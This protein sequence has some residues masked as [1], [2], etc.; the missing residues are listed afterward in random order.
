MEIIERIKFH[1][2]KNPFYKKYLQTRVNDMRYFVRSC[3]YYLKWYSWKKDKEATGN[4]LYFIID[5]EIK[6]PGLSDRYKA[7]IGCYYI[8]K[9]SGFDFKIVF[10][11]PFK[12]SDY[13]NENE[14]SWT[15]GF[16]ELSYSLQNTRIIPYNGGGKVPRLNKKVKQYHV[17]SY[18]GYDILET[19]KIPNYKIEWGK[20][21][22]SLFTPK[23]FIRKEIQATGFEK[24]AYIAIHL[25]F[26]NALEHF[27][28]EQFNTLSEANKEALIVRCL[29]QIKAIIG[30]NRGVSVI[31]FS[32]SQVFLKRVKE[33]PVHVLDGKIGH[34]SFENEREVIIKTFL[35]FYMISSARQIYVI[36]APEMYG[37]VFSYYA[38]LTGQKEVITCEV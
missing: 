31:V 20:L 15:A 9:Q 5:P 30:K 37:T 22:N 33:L 6:H 36:R 18:I 7:I 35:D 34:V 13:L 14:Q 23:D 16:D 4:T 10:E 19:N 38:A 29:R 2:R 1:L 11:T 28:G 17:Y 24:N 32:D 12:L 25:R 3:K 26:V 27:E 8:A 21:Y